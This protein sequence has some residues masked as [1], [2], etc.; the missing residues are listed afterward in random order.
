MNEFLLGMGFVVT[1]N[2][3]SNQSGNQINMLLKLMYKVKVWVKEYVSVCVNE[4]DLKFL[5]CLDINKIK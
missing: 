4:R 5:K 1:C 2:Q 3:P